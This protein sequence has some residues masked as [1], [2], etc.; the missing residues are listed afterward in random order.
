MRELGKYLKELKLELVDRLLACAKLVI[1]FFLKGNVTLIY[2]IFGQGE[3]QFEGAGV[4]PRD[5]VTEVVYR[6]GVGVRH[7]C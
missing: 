6:R 2:L 4:G 7:L 1:H 5:V 3:F